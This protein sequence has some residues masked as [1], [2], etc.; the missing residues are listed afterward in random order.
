M[1]KQKRNTLVLYAALAFFALSTWSFGQSPVVLSPVPKLQFFD[2]S[3]RP[4]AFGC[5]FSYVSGSNTPLATYTDS[6][7]VSVNTNPVDLDS[8]GFAGSGSSGIWLQAG[9]AYRLTV[10]SS[11]GSHCASGSTLYSVDGIGGGTS[12]LTTVVSYS[13]TPTFSIQGQIQLFEITLTGDAVAQPLTAVGIQPPALVIFQITQDSAGGHSFTWP[14]N[15]VG[16]AQIGSNLNQVSTQMFVWNGTT[17]TAIGPA[18]IGNGPWLSTGSI[19]A[20]GSITASGAFVGPTFISTCANPASV[21][22]FRLCKTDTVNW[23]NNANSADAGI[24]Q[25]ASDRG[26]LSFP[27]GLVLT[28]TTPDIFFGG[29]T[30]SF[31]RWKRNGTALNARLA[32]DS[33]DAP[34]T[35]ASGGFSQPVTSTSTTYAVGGPELSAPASPAAGQQSAFFKAGAGLCSKDSAGVVYC[36]QPAGSMQEVKKT[37]GLC[38]TDAA[39]YHACSDTLTWPVAFADTNYYVVCSGIVNIADGADGQIAATANIGS[40]T[41]STVTV[42]TQTQRSA[43]AAQFDQIHCIGIHP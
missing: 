12:L 1:T 33:A 40:F 39:S 23:R 28:G 9:Q 32:D 41:A 17:A 5:V 15:S 6:T 31:P 26:V 19:L 16:G 37:S 14:A 30:A 8:G 36:T 4:L 35:A 10:K 2:A 34:I 11:G 3:G 20:L 42:K 18:V 24:S 13:P 38:T 22:T 29:T 21:G 43:P 27:G 7:G 25:D